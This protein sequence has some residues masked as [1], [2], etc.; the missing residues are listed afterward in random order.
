[1][2]VFNDRRVDA[3]KISASRNCS[4]DGDGITYLHGLGIR[5]GGHREISDCARKTGRCIWRQW[6]YLKC[7][8]FAFDLHLAAFAQLTEW[9]RE[10]RIGEWI[11]LIKQVE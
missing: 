3:V 9:I 6:L 10:E 7:H 5:I 2:L 4:R 1:M 11:I 8:S